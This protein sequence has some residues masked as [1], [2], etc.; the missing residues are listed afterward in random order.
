MSEGLGYCFV[1]CAGAFGRA[2]DV[3]DFRALPLNDLRRQFFDDV[4]CISR[5]T[6]PDDGGMDASVFDCYGRYDV[7]V[8]AAA[9]IASTGLITGSE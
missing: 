8:R 4:A 6:L 7:A 1:K 5:Q 2:G 9:A 3:V